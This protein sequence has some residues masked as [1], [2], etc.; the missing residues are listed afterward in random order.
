MLFTINFNGIYFNNWRNMH[1]SIKT[2]WDSS[3]NK[4][5][6][7]K[8]EHFSSICNLLF[9]FMPLFS[10]RE[11]SLIKLWQCTLLFS[12][13]RIVITTTCY[14]R[15][16]VSLLLLYCSGINSAFI[17]KPQPILFFSKYFMFQILWL[18]KNKMTLLWKSFPTSL[19]MCSQIYQQISQSALLQLYYIS[20]DCILNCL[21]NS[22]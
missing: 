7:L 5:E 13:N 20:L 12:P 6:Y 17:R 19:V 16:L 10:D 11:D 15:D 1:I 18:K 21:L 3:K 22:K 14:T 8:C 9:C 4:Y 2:W